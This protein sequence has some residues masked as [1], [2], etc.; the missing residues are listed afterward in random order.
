MALLSA[1]NPWDLSFL[2]LNPRCFP[3]QFQA[4]S[5]FCYHLPSWIITMLG[6]CCALR[7]KNVKHVV[8]LRFGCE[9]RQPRGVFTNTNHQQQ[10]AAPYLLWLLVSF[11]I[12]SAQTWKFARLWETGAKNESALCATC[13]Q[14]YVL[15]A[16]CRR[17][18]TFGVKAGET[19]KLCLLLVLYRNHHHRARTFSRAFA[20]EKQLRAF[21]RSF[22][23]L[24]HVFYFAPCTLQGGEKVNS[25][26]AGLNLSFLPCH[27]ELF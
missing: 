26:G 9:I 3:L 7:W 8:E 15:R 16:R 22:H 17:R 20:D 13:R 24:F 1:R 6:W 21:V 19:G 25:A 4:R 18:T 11:K 27:L 5:V 23:P 12:R 14:V 10:P 2:F